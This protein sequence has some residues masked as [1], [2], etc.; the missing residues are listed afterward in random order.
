MESKENFEWRK[1][2]NCTNG[3]YEIDG[4]NTTGGGIVI[5]GADLYDEIYETYGNKRIG[6]F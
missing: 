5:H 2:N 3:I 6:V 4:A 1:Q